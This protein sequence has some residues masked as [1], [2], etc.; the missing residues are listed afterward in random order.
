VKVV[1]INGSSK[2]NGNT[3]LAIQ[4]VGEGLAT[5]GI[6]LARLDIG[7]EKLHGCVGCG[8]CRNLKNRRCRLDDDMANTWMQELFS[9][10][11]I[12]LA[13]PVYYAG[14]NGAL[15]SF[16]DRAFFVAA[17]NGALFRHKVGVGVVAVRR[18]G[19]LT[20]IGQLNCY[21]TISEMYLPASNYW[22][23]IY[24]LMP[25]EAEKDVEGRQ[26]LKVLGEN[27]GWLMRV[28]EH[29]RTT[30]PPPAPQEKVMLNFIR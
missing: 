6:D 9:A 13:S 3:A 19:A 8:A 18:A 15:K 2:V 23:M 4:T 1:A 24:G 10:D 14:I 27:M 28:I 22:N 16:L 20:A 26:T 17:S 11:G 30:L 12:I 7:S 5:Q 25:G 21:L 29:G